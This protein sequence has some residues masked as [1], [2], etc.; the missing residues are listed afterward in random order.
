MSEPLGGSFAVECPAL[1][2]VSAARLRLGAGLV[3]GGLISG[4]A[5][6][7]GEST[8]MDFHPPNIDGRRGGCNGLLLRRDLGVWQFFPALRQP[9]PH[10]P[11]P[12]LP[13]KGGGN[14]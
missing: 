11:P 2:S 3:S 6:I 1:G 13:H 4:P 14:Q 9:S 12:T 5:A 8:A 10:P 7:V